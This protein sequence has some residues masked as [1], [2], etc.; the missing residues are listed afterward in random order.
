MTDAGVIWRKIQDASFFNIFGNFR[1]ALEVGGEYAA[2][3]KLGQAESQGPAIV[4]WFNYL[5]YW[6]WVCNAACRFLPLALGSRRMVRHGGY[7]SFNAT[8]GTTTWI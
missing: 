8:R 3:L 2:S 1:Q 6:I 4:Q 7:G 5:P